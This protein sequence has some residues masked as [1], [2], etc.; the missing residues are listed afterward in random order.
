[1]PYDN[2]IF[3]RQISWSCTVAGNFVITGSAANL[4]VAE[5]AEKENKQFPAGRVR[6]AACP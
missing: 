6:N 5:G 1:M 2:V 3:V 4:I